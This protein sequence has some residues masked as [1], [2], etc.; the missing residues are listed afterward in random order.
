MA[1]KFDYVIVGAGSAGCV[2]AN[3]LT[4][5][6]GVSV[7]LLEAGG[8]DPWWDWRIRMPAAL[9]YPMNGT[10][11]S[12][13]YETEPEPH[14]DGRKLHCPRG[15]VLG[16]SSSINGMVYI[17]GNA[18]D[19]DGW[20][21]ADASLKDWDYAHCLPYFR[22]A[23][24]RE[25]GGDEYH[26][27]DGPLYVTRGDHIGPL[28]KA[29]VD[30]AGEAGYSPTEDLNGYKQEGVGPMD[31]TTRK[32]IRW[33]TSL[34]YLRPAMKR[35]NLT[36][37]TRSQ[38][39]GLSMSGNRVTGLTYRH[40][41]VD[42]HVEAGEV[43]LCG[44]PINSPQLLK[45]AGI[46]PADELREFGVDVVQDLP[47]VGENLQDHL[48][49]TLQVECLQPVSIYKYYNLLGKAWVGANWLFARRG[50]G[51][52][53]QFEVG[54][55][56][57]SRTGVEYPDLQYHFFPMAVRYDGQSPTKSH[58]FQAHVGPMRSKSRGWVRLRS[59]DPLDP[60]R[61]RFNYMSHPDDW[62]EFRDS[63]RLTREILQQDAMKPFAG[64]EISPGPAV[65]S[66]ADI[67]AYLKNAVESSYHPSGT[68]KMGSGDDAVVDHAGRVHGVDGL[69]VVDSS[70]MPLIAS[71]NL[72]APTIMIAEKMADAIK[73]ATPLPPS[74]AAVFRAKDYREQQR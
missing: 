67:D 74:D 47:G 12:W 44:G 41:G 23:E 33:S 50:I 13:N 52:T 2:L 11:Y 28:F 29:F 61:V 17:R 24:T 53:N 60:M 34:A 57:R 39:M 20:A 19:Y 9:A 71:G 58:G 62:Q 25:G 64:E 43:V 40:R 1:Q 70:I 27:D 26:G 42:E 36:L 48:E 35:D 16:G 37:M 7:L 38:V 55:F 8:N 49:I 21:E 14:L 30:A 56:I 54:G 6:S 18:L 45:L 73:G 68:C 59:A 4:E 3:R 15:R 22:K 63:I 51:T 31:R 46:G 65:Q 72:N 66:D 5:Y 10:T 69:R 32:G